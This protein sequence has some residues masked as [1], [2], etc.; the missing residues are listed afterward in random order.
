MENLKIGKIVKTKKG[1]TCVI[2]DILDDEAIIF[3]ITKME[4][5]KIKTKDI[6]EIIGEANCTTMEIDGKKVTIK[7]TEEKEEEKTESDDNEES[8]EKDNNFTEMFGEL[9]KLFG[10]AAIS[11]GNVLVDIGKEDKDGE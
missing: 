9:I 7:G 6:K 5:D 2:V 1:D 10:Q 3:N 4:P 8:E 11:L